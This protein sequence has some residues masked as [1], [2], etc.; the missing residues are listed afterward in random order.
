M[1]FGSTDCYNSGAYWYKD[2]R[3][4]KNNS[5]D[6]PLITA[7][8]YGHLSCV[9]ALIR[10]GADVNQTGQQSRTPLIEA[11]MQVLRTGN[12]GGR[13]DKSGAEVNV[14]R[15][16]EHASAERDYY[17]YS[18]QSIPKDKAAVDA[19]TEGVSSNTREKIVVLLIKSGANVNKKDCTGETALIKALQRGHLR[20]AKLLI[21]S[22]ASMNV[23]TEALAG[24]LTQAAV[25][26]DAEI[27][28]FIVQSRVSAKT[29]YIH[30]CKALMAATV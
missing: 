2:V 24:V 12:I 23:N 4:S 17:K 3:H 25:R 6:S 1:N 11:V 22:K 15:L 10:V 8:R 30:S 5:G 27:V 13:P 21:E 16:L 26:G 29:M 18:F 19:L 14:A 9:E 20:L 28:R 7:V